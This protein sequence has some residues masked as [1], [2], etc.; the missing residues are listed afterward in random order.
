MKDIITVPP[1]I[2]KLQKTSIDSPTLILQF[3]YVGKQP[4]TSSLTT[5]TIT[6]PNRFSLAPFQS[7]KIY[8]PIMVL[9]SL[10]ASSIVYAPELLYRLGLH[11]TISVIPTND[12]NLYIIVYNHTPQPI[13]IE[14]NSLQFY[15]TTTLSY[16]KHVNVPFL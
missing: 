15:C 13:E 11:C 1:P 8:F 2:F 16:N 7:K 9:S 14:K 3:K 4:H 10:S 6:N 5:I 12:T